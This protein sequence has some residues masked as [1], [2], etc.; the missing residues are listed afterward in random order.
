MNY[1]RILFLLF[2]STSL[3]AQSEPICDSPANGSDWRLV[4]PNSLPELGPKAR[5]QMTG[6]GAQMRLQFLDEGEP[7]PKILY[8]GTPS[9]GLFRTMDCTVE[10]PV[11]ENITDSTRLPV[12]GVRG[13]D[14]LTK[15]SGEPT[16]YIGTGIRY[17]LDIKRAYGIGVLRSQ[18]GGD[19]WER[20]GLQFKQPGGK[21]HTCHDV[22]ID[23]ENP[24]IIHALC[25]PHYHRS[26]DG[27]ETF[28]KM[29]T[30]THPCPAGW[31]KSFRD[32]VAKVDDPNIL[33]LSID[34]NFFYRSTDRGETWEEFDLRSFGIEKDIVR[35]DVA[36]SPLNPE[37]VYIGCRA[38]KK[39]SLLRSLDAGVTWE[40][41]MEKNIRTSYERNAIAISSYDENI[42]YFGGLYIDK[43]VLGDEK[44]YVR[45]IS[46][47]LHLDHR[48]LVAVSD[49]N[50]GDILYSAND[51]GLYRGVQSAE[52][53][54]KWEWRDISG[55]GMNN[56][57]FYG[58]GVAED[59]SV[60][61]GGTQDNGMLVGDR[62]GNFFKPRIG[63]D[64]VDAVIDLY[65]TDVLYGTSW[66]LQ[67]PT[68]H[69]STDAGQT[70]G[71]PL[72][73]GFSGE[74]DVYYFPMQTHEDGYLYAAKEQVYRLLP[75]S[76]EWEQLGDLD[77]P[78]NL[79]YKVTAMNVAPSNSNY[80]YVYSDK[81]YRTV[82][83]QSDSVIWTNI[84]EGLGWA[85]RTDK[86]G[87]V[88]T[89]IE[90]HPEDPSKIWVG[91]GV[92][93]S[94]F[95]VYYSDDAGLTWTLITKEGLPNWPI[96]AMAV[97]G[98]TNGAVYAGTDV[99][100]FYNPDATNPESKW[101]CFNGGLPVS[102]IIDLEMNYCTGTIIAGT[103]G[104]GIWES[105]FATPS[106]FS[107][108]EV[109]EDLTW[110]RKIMRTDL[111]VKDGST[112]TLKGEVR[113]ASG[114][115][116]IVERNAKLVLDG[117]R[118][119]SLCGDTWEGVKV[120]DDLNLFQRIF[121]ARAG[122]FELK[123]GAVLEDVRTE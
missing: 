9:G 69:R 22:L 94:R 93:H 13:F 96:N 104:R 37:L 44:P 117:V 3:F 90:V 6:T 14:I 8:A 43:V 49:G 89:S 35:A 102:F 33:F 73:K 76:E 59:F 92:Y 115:Q 47:G 114:T 64:A 62:E 58:I 122:Q 45:G 72:K 1:F 70:F 11:W 5:P 10:M 38:G 99:G 41:V 75:D 67:P 83:A 91:F 97:Q 51:G 54:H 85:I 57:Q 12:L 82:N 15:K 48:D 42:L 17:P 120:E 28:S 87:G 24:Q 20:T 66:A 18:D 101:Q 19:S 98:G 88:V 36:V 84:S 27:G 53:E 61:L 79:P 65:D 7:D 106:N 26:M 55:T 86:G 78:T 121:G 110:E 81:L 74:A 103:H 109:K 118:V 108:E 56:T 116:I 34:G 60:V 21:K 112:L 46:S 16:I 77:L 113:M 123:N 25:G 63:G 2:F 30:L 32:I 29:K 111:V 4:G 95:K 52:N 50:G 31:G 100:V 23:A 105:P 71:K 40:L 68:V 107:A 119:K 80:I 39:E